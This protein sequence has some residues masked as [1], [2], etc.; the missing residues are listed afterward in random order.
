MKIFGVTATLMV[1]QNGA[2]LERYIG[3]IMGADFTISDRGL[4]SKL[5]WI[6][7]LYATAGAT[8][9]ATRGVVTVYGANREEWLRT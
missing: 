4:A 3:K 6:G 9:Y 7:H 1:V 2:N 8:K 5:S